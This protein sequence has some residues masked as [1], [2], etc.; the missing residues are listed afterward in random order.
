MGTVF[1]SAILCKLQKGSYWLQTNNFRD[2]CMF[3]S[4]SLKGEIKSSPC[5]QR[6]CVLLL[7]SD[8]VV[9]EV[10]DCKLKYALSG[11]GRNNKKGALFGM[12]NP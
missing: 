12:A 11:E 2:D 9:E 10:L 1:C 5:L 7:V 8:E 3:G 4:S 6:S